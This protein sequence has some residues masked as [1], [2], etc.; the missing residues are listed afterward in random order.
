MKLVRRNLREN[1][2]WNESIHEIG[3]NGTD[4]GEGETIKHK[5]NTE[6]EQ[7]GLE[8]V[9]KVKE[10]EMQGEIPILQNDRGEEAGS[11]LRIRTRQ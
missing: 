11:S 5:R 8:S 3:E 7:Y 4:G 2:R 6:V 1:V 10:R 9:A